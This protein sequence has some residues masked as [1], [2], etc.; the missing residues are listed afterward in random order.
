MSFIV[1]LWWKPFEIVRKCSFTKHSVQ[2]NAQMQL[3]NVL[4]C[5]VRQELAASVAR[6]NKNIKSLDLD[7][8]YQNQSEPGE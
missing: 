8:N 1:F 5:S 3:H 7:W 6:N 4:F 2:K